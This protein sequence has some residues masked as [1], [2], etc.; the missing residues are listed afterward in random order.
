MNKQ[1]DKENIYCRKLGH[2]VNFQ[3]CREEHNKYPCMKIMDC[4]FERLS[5]KDYI[6]ENYTSEQTNYLFKPP[7]DKIS[8]LMDLI[9]Q[10]KKYQQ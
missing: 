9:E 8:T 2:A 1:Y 3:Y 6:D 10:A 4:W 5:I 7:A